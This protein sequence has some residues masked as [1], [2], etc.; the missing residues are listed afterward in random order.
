MIR[1]QQPAFHP[2]ATQF[3][4]HTGDQLFSFWRQSGDRRQSIFCIYN[5]SDGNQTLLLRDLN[6]I[7]T[8]SWR[9]LISGRAYEE[10]DEL[11]EI[12][13]YQVLWITNS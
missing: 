2:N 13:P 5:I 3:T 10:H 9:D 12:E 6:L 4:L 11:L 8:D 7:S 1:Q